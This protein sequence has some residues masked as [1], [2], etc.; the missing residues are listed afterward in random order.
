MNAMI[1]ESAPVE[2]EG[3]KQN[4]KRARYLIAIGALIVLIAILIV[5][6][7]RSARA[8]S[9]PANASHTYAAMNVVPVN[10]NSPSHLALASMQDGFAAIAR[11]V[12]PAVVSIRV[13]KSVR[14]PAVFQGMGSFFRVFGDVPGFPPAQQMPRT[15]HEVGSGSGMIVRSDGWILTNDHVVGDADRVTVKLSDGRE[16]N[17]KVRRDFR[18]D[19]ALVKI[20]ATN[21]PSVRFGN[22]DDVRVGQWA[23]AFGSPFTLDGTM[24]VGIISARKRQ[25]SIGIGDQQRFYPSLLQTDASINPGNSGGPLVDIEGRVIGIDVAI[26][27]PTGGSVGIGFAIPSN[28]AREVMEQLITRGQVIRGFLGVVPRALTAAERD[29][30]GVQSGGALVQTVSDSTPAERAGL[31]PGDVILRYDG[32]PVADDIALRD[33]VAD[34][35]PGKTVSI[36]VR[37]NGHERTVQA[38]LDRAPSAP[39]EASPIPTGSSGMLGLR[40]QAATPDTLRDL[41]LPSGARGVVVTDVQ[42][43]SLADDAGL[44]PGDVIMRANGREVASEADLRNASRS[45]PSGH[46]LSLVVAR[47]KSRTLV[48]IP[49]P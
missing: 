31:Q 19:I 37:R 39:G 26:N 23:I 35:A 28:T 22:S 13:D 30:F 36:E 5:E 49:I 6:L 43:G 1:P 10:T 32:R 27:S 40:V 48:T 12:E 33:M 4:T 17:G 46:T 25:D 16:F 2:T 20:D 38:T 29:Q 15:F 45:T 44:Q 7:A 42:N 21:L 8:S 11:A 9:P 47:G 34:T 18:S 14:A 41:H 24:T 3:R